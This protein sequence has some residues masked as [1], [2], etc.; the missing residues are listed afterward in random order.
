MDIKYTIVH[1]GE[2]EKDCTL[3][4]K[5]FKKFGPKDFD[6]VLESI[7]TSFDRPL[8]KKRGVV[9]CTNNYIE[10]YNQITF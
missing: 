8:P 7:S 4:Q 3:S 9:T 2:G 6:L 10:R 1:G 5:K